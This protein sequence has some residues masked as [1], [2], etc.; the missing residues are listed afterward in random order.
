M[1]ARPSR[2]RSRSTS[3]ST[4]SWNGSGKWSTLPPRGN[5]RKAETDDEAAQLYVT[6][7]RFPTTLRSRTIGYIWDSTEPAGAS[8]PSA[9]VSTVHYIVVRS[10]SADL[11]KWITETRNVLEDFKKIYGENPGEPAGGITLSINSQ[12]TGFPGRVLLRQNPLQEAL[13]DRS[14]MSFALRSLARERAFALALASAI[15]VLLFGRTL[16]HGLTLNWWTAALFLWLFATVL[17]SAFAVVRHAESLAHHYGEPYGTLILTLS[18]VAIEVIMISAMMLNED[19]DPTLGRDTIYATLMIIVNGLIGLAMLLGGLR[20]GEQQ[21]NLKSSTAFFSMILVLAAVGLYLPVVV[22]AA[23]RITYEVFL[24]A[25]SCLLYLLFLRIQTKEHR[26]Y[27]VSEPSAGARLAGHAG[28]GA[29]GWYHALLLLGTLSLIGY[30][31]ESVALIIDAGVDQL[32]LPVEVASL[33]VAL[34]ILAPESLTA[35]RAGLDNDM[36]RV[37]NICLG[38]ALSTVSLTIPAV[39]LVGS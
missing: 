30:L 16:L 31:A 33:L 36:Q 24:I 25:L 29:P 37:V 6:F 2:R 5:A 21:Y 38:S 28:D 7:P 26:Y 39:L 13:N 35:L 14:G 19:P 4:R 1:T 23:S 34:L 15:V 17:V 12:N 32:R 11:G 22:P 3:S 20:Y 8:F 27:F 9:K 10:G 18:A